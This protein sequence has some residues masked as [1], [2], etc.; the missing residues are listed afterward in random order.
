[1]VTLV[2]VKTENNTNKVLVWDP[3][4]RKAS[5]DNYWADL[6]EDI[7]KY[8]KSTNSFIIVGRK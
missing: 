4:S 3:G 5:R 6:N 1:M 8:L 2:G 7:V